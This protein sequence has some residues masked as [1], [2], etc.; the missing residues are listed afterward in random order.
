MKYTFVT[1]RG[2]GVAYLL[3][4]GVQLLRALRH[5]SNSLGGYLVYACLTFV[6][7]LIKSMDCLIQTS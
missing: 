2:I 5:R 7:N 6:H 1:V 4:L 3:H